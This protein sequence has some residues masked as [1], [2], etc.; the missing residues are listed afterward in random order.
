VRQRIKKAIEETISREATEVWKNGMAPYSDNEPVDAHLWLNN[1]HQLMFPVVKKELRIIIWENIAEIFA[2][3]CEDEETIQMVQELLH[4]KR[5]PLWTREAWEFRAVN[6]ASLYGAVSAVHGTLKRSPYTGNEAH[7]GVF[8]RLWASAS[9]GAL[10]AAKATIQSSQEKVKDKEKW[11]KSWA[12][13]WEDWEKAWEAAPVPVRAKIVDSMIRAAVIDD[14]EYGAGILLQEMRED[15]IH[16]LKARVLASVSNSK[17]L[18]PAG[19]P[20]N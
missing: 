20:N 11:N 3:A 13:V 17:L 10:S 18:W 12:L 8:D 5:S 6:I 7:E 2:S 15:K 1:L 16:V 4:R 9:A 14:A 19:Y